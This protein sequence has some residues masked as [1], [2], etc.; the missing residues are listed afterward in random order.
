VQTQKPF[1]DQDQTSTLHT[2]RC[3]NLYWP[4]LVEA[5]NGRQPKGHICY[6]SFHIW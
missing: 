6:S 1:G 2:D 5:S 4:R 3:R